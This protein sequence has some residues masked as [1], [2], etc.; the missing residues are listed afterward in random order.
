[1]VKKIAIDITAK[2]KIIEKNTFFWKV[3]FLSNLTLFNKTL[4]FVVL[5]LSESLL[6]FETN[7]VFSAISLSVFFTDI[8]KQVININSNYLL[9]LYIFIIINF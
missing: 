8:F 9:K 6:F 1:M 2:N 7:S 3:F 5:I 4:I